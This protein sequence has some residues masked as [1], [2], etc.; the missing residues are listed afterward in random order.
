MVSKTTPDIF[1]GITGAED[2]LALT[3]GPVE[4]SWNVGSY[5]SV[6]V[7][8]DSGTSGHYIDDAII[9]KLRDKLDSYQVRDVP[10]KSQPSVVDNWAVLCRDCS[11]ASSSTEK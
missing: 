3:A 8:I 11:V 7:L 10:H 1:G 5:S 4:G 6:N 9:P 2:G